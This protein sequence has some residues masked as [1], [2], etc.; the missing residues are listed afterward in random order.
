M[1]RLTKKFEIGCH[2]VVETTM[3]TACLGLCVML[4]TAGCQSARDVA[5]ASASA[6]VA[7]PVVSSYGAAYGANNLH[8][9]SLVSFKADPEHF[10]EPIT[11][12]QIEAMHAVDNANSFALAPSWRYMGSRDGV[13]FLACNPPLVGFRRIYR[14]QGVELE[15]ERTFDLTADATRWRLMDFGLNAKDDPPKFN[16][17]F[18]HSP[19][20]VA[21][22]DK[23][24]NPP[25]PDAPIER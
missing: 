23:P 9:T 4:S 11:M 12:K 15:I 18:E 1:N 3:R 6:A 20:T 8:Q 25:S 7:A 21:P 2:D 14:I 10:S 19:S 17:L 5:G 13:H 22:N 24:L 16:H